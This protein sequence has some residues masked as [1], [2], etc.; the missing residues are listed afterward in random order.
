VT[1]LF[2]IGTSLVGGYIFGRLTAPQAQPKDTIT[3]EQ[4][5]EMLAQTEKQKANLEEIKRLLR[6]P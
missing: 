5:K 3:H 6:I 2:L 4:V 1:V